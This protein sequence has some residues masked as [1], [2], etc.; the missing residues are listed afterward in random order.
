MEPYKKKK[1]K[2]LIFS[3]SRNRPGQRT[4]G[5]D[6]SRA[7]E[8]PPPQRL[9]AGQGLWLLPHPLL[10][11]LLRPQ[12]QH[13]SPLPLLRLRRE[14]KQL[15]RGSRLRADLR[16]PL[17]VGRAGAQAEGLSEAGDGLKDEEGV[18]GAGGGATA[19]GEEVFSLFLDE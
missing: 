5:P 10:P 12:D 1:K 6:L 15:P 13:L 9:R 4:Q 2:N 19:A 7:E 11:L 16:R 17:G 18:D 14:R 8:R 3:L